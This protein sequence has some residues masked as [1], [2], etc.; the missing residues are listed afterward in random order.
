MAGF[1]GASG[2]EVQFLRVTSLHLGSRD[3]PSV[4]RGLGKGPATSLCLGFL[5]KWLGDA[6]AY[7][8]GWPQDELR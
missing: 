3:P 7:F 1:S 2:M 8:S 6:G 5:V 4:A